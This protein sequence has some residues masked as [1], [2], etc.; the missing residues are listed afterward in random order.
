MEIYFRSSI[1]FFD[2]LARARVCVRV[3]PVH[4]SYSSCLAKCMTYNACSPCVGCV[5]LCARTQS[6]P[7]NSRAFQDAEDHVF[8]LF[9]VCVC[10][11]KR[12][13]QKVGESRFWFFFYLRRANNFMVL[14]TESVF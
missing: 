10:A 5:C 1:V 9:G 13:L 12:K 11:V 8:G 4:L 2:L 7:N 14:S 6:Q 3:T